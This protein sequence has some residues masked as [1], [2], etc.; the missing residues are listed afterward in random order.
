V[1]DA[2][3][4]ARAAAQHHPSVKPHIDN[5]IA[6]ARFQEPARG[7]YRAEPLSSGVPQRPTTPMFPGAPATPLL[8]ALEALQTE[9]VW[10]ADCAEFTDA[11]NNARQYLHAAGHVDLAA[12]AA[13]ALVTEGL[14]LVLLPA[15]RVWDLAAGLGRQVDDFVTPM[16]SMGFLLGDE[17]SASYRWDMHHDRLVA[18][19]EDLGW[20]ELTE[21]TVRF[22]RGRARCEAALRDTHGDPQDAPGKRRYG[23]YF[24]DAA[25]TD[26]FVLE[27]HHELPDWALGPV[28]HDLPGLAARIEA[29]ATE[30]RLEFRPPVPAIELARALGSSRRASPT[31]RPASRCR[32]STY[33]PRGPSCSARTT[34][35]ATSTCAAHPESARSSAARSASG[36]G[37]GEK[38]PSASR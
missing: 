7:P 38:R 36:S 22:P 9:L 21:Y 28:D 37:V 33:R 31:T 16:S 34:S 6:V 30:H 32:A 2:I 17:Y 20:R 35:S 27:W 29:A 5:A 18:S 10:A 8:A 1:D 4:R 14:G 13:L 19:A 23:L 25:D 3:D 26:A 11:T 12:R 15:T 24:T